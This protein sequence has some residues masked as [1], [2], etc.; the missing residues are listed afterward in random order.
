MKNI[1]YCELS[2]HIEFKNVHKTVIHSLA[3][4]KEGEVVKAQTELFHVQSLSGSGPRVLG[5]RSR[6]IAGL[7]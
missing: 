4:R 2:G 6:V 3:H 7:I 5:I 1:I